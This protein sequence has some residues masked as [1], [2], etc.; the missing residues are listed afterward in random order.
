MEYV[1]CKKCGH[2]QTLTETQQYQCNADNCF[3]TEYEF[4]DTQN[5][6][7]IICKCGSFLSTDELGKLPVE[8]RDNSYMLRDI[9]RCPHCKQILY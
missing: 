3:N 5:L 1:K 7:G 2:I 8:K 6:S 9:K 4:V